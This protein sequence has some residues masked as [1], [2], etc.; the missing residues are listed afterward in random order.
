MTAR[1]G[2]NPA[3]AVVSH[4]HA[5]HRPHGLR[6]G[7]PPAAARYAGP[8]ALACRHRAERRRRRRAFRLRLP[9][10]VRALLCS[11]SPPRPGS[12]WRCASAIR[13]ATGWATM[14]RPLLLAFDILQLAALL[15]LTGGLQNPFAMLFLA[16]V[17]I[18]ATALPPERTLALG[19]PRGRLGP[20][21][22]LVAPAA[23]LGSGP[24]LDAALPLRHRDLDGDPARHRLHR[25]LCLARRRGGAPARRGARRDRA[26][27]RP[28]AAPVPARRPRGR[29]RA[30]ARHAARD[31]RARRQGARPRP[32][33]GGAG[34]R[35]T[36]SSCASR[37][38][39]AAASWRS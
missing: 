29:R 28:R 12:I 2:R 5:R 36:S 10:A 3:A 13:R 34:R 1:R 38:S 26:G 30:R 17:L 11:S 31:D 37:S 18:S 19:L 27:A 16:P 22:V 7:R 23:A 6:A 9:A 25:R 32:A 14:R 24:A 4:S 35:T 21:L 20:I 39:A 15:Y 8:A 33:E